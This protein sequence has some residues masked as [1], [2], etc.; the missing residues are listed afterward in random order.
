MGSDGKSQ[1]FLYLLEN[2]SR[3]DS[4]VRHRASK[5]ILKAGLASV[6]VDTGY[7]CREAK[8]GVRV[9]RVVRRS[10]RRRRL[11]SSM[12]CESGASRS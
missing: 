10:R 9:G 6:A 12:K 11:R 2:C 7:G 1:R 3:S 8:P 4:F 5:Q